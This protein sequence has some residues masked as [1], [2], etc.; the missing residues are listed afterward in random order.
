M[1]YRLFFIIFCL[2]FL[3]SYPMNTPLAQTQIKPDIRNYDVFVDK[4]KMPSVPCFGLTPDQWVANYIGYNQLKG[5]N[6]KFSE[7]LFNAGNQLVGII[8]HLSPK[9]VKDAMN[10]T[11]D[12]SGNQPTWVGSI[13]YYQGGDPNQIISD[14]LITAQDPITTTFKKI[15]FGNY[16]SSYI[17][18]EHL[19]L[20]GGVY[21]TQR[22]PLTPDPY[23]QSKCP[24]T[25]PGV[26]QESQTDK[27]QGVNTFGGFL[28]EA[29]LAAACA[30][31]QCRCVET[32]MYIRTDSTIQYDTDPLCRS[33]GCTQEQLA[34]VDEK[35]KAV[36]EAQDSG[37]WINAQVKPGLILGKLVALAEY[38]FQSITGKVV[39]QQTKNRVNE[40]SAPS[41]YYTT[42]ALEVGMDF[43]NCKLFPFAKRAQMP[44]CNTN[45]LANLIGN[46]K[47]NLQGT[48]SQTISE[49]NESM[50]EKNFEE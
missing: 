1:K 33:V 44:E 6:M 7:D 18:R 19:S 47:N 29:K 35:S 49:P 30:S 10:K 4:R 26:E 43:L 37:G 50:P 16:L 46:I 15:R 13:C 38:L 25:P 24:V 42:K 12:E 22:D 48:P 3:L 2:F 21:N 20:T 27:G 28:E 9:I 14:E 17:A 31:I 5:D 34:V 11:M 8:E 39:A 45:W 32:E 41:S 40:P 36:Q 23:K